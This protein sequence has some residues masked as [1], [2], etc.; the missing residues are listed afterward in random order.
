MLGFVMDSHIYYSQYYFHSEIFTIKNPISL[1]LSDSEEDQGVNFL[2]G[3]VGCVLE[4]KVNER[5]PNFD[6]MKN[7]VTGSCPL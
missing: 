7:I 4:V 1:W 2:P 3:L 5:N 6:V